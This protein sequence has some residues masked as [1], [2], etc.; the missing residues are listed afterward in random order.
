V[1]SPE[2]YT[3][4][5]LERL[6][7]E[8]EENHNKSNTANNASNNNNPPSSTVAA[9]TTTTKSTSPSPPPLDMATSR[10]S[11]D[12]SSPS[13]T[14]EPILPFFKHAKLHWRRHSLSN[15]LGNLFD[16]T[17]QAFTLFVF[18][19]IDLTVFWQ[20]PRQGRFG[21]HH[22][23]GINLSSASGRDSDASSLSGSMTAGVGSNS[24]GGSG[25]SNTGN[26]GG[27]GSNTG[28]SS[29]GPGSLSRRSSTLSKRRSL[30]MLS[31]RTTS[32]TRRNSILSVAS[33]MTLSVEDPIKV[34]VTS[35]S[36]IN[37]DFLEKG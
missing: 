4:E 22:L 21:H 1:I 31:V 6:D 8:N 7:Q 20:V 29:S 17:V 10:I 26:S 2:R 36:E 3:Q 24:G 9:V 19:E 5:C 18:G 27:G 28:G 15:S 34:L 23:L 35:P 25:G 11:F 12:G 16:K 33:R 14:V 13:S 30:S 37:H 32:I